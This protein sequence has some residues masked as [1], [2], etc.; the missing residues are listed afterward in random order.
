MLI[1]NGN[2]NENTTNQ[3]HNGNYVGRDH[4]EA[5]MNTI[6]PESDAL[7]PMDTL[8]IIRNLSEKSQKSS[9]TLSFNI[10]QHK[11]F[12]ILRQ[13]MKI[14]LQYFNSKDKFSALRSIQSLSI[15][16]DDDIFTSILSSL[17][18]NVYNLSLNE[19]ML[20]DA[21]LSSSQN[22]NNQL[23]DELRK[24]LIERFNVKMSQ[25]PIDLCY[26]IKVRRMMQFIDRNRNKIINEVFVNIRECAANAEIDIFTPYEAMDVIIRLSN[27]GND[28]EYFEK[29]L[30]KAFNVWHTGEVTVEMVE[31]MLTLLVNRKSTL[32]Y[33]LYKDARLI[34][35]CS[36]VAIDSCNMEKCFNFQ[37]Q[38]NRL[39]SGSK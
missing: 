11:N 20:F 9:T 22:N 27:F 38:F 6:P 26:F 7:S 14:S 21:I 24:S 25:L 1:R 18:E 12:A 2:G 34:E 17:H 36:K 19:I 33:G 15:P 35:K 3:R 39:V 10:V 23:V 5:I 4:L 28:C 13:A 8:N 30:E 29:V 32:D 16:A 31:I 37:R